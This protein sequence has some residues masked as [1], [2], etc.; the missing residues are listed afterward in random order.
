MVSSDDDMR[1]YALMEDSPESLQNDEVCRGRLHRSGTNHVVHKSFDIIAA[2]KDVLAKP[3]GEIPEN[4]ERGELLVDTAMELETNTTKGVAAENSLML[5]RGLVADTGLVKIAQ[6]FRSGTN[7]RAIEIALN[8]GMPLRIAAKI[9][10]EERHYFDERLAPLIAS[11]P[12]IEFIGEIDDRGRNDLLGRAAAFLFPIEWSE[13]FGLVMIE[14]MA[15]GTPVIAW[16]RGSVPEVVEEGVT[17]YIVDTIEAG[18]EAVRQID[19]L[20][21]ARCR[22]EFERR[23]VASRMAADYV[24][25]YESALAARVRA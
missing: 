8:A 4:Y 12:L 2:F 19:R 16:R 14:A 7:D 15:C 25:L 23:F 20:S 18:V 21:R 11:S 22:Q 17:G 9:Y 10:P 1:P 6:T 3:V 5:E 13:P 24:A